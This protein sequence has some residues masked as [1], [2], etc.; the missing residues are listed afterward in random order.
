LATISTQGFDWCLFID[1]VLDRDLAVPAAT[2]LTYLT[3]EL[4]WSIPTAVIDRIVGQVRE[5]FLSEFAANYRTFVSEVPTE[6]RAIYQAECIRSRRFIERVSTPRKVARRRSRVNAALTDI[7]AGQKILLP[8]P[9]GVGRTDRIQFRLLLE[10][11]DE[12]RNASS[13]TTGPSALVLLRCFDNIPLELGRLLV[14][15]KQSEPQELRGEIDGA[16]VVGRGID[17]LWLKVTPADPFWRRK[18]RGFRARIVRFASKG[19]READWLRKLRGFRARITRFAS[20][21]SRGANGV[22]ESQGTILRGNFE[23][24]IP[25]S[26]V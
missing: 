13:L 16:L 19:P 8:M 14:R 25:T 11:A 21:G 6:C 18:L 22:N 17:Q 24:T 2:A 23:A 5:P 12:W 10:V 15:R 20:K 7:K 9:S 26:R 1:V 4:Q 3:E